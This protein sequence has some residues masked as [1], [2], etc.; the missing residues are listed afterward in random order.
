MSTPHSCGP[1]TPLGLGG[2]FAGAIENKA[3]GSPF[4]VNRL[5]VSMSVYADPALWC[6]SFAVVPGYRVPL[7]MADRRPTGAADRINWWDLTIDAHA[8]PGIAAL[9]EVLRYQADFPNAD[10]GRV[11]SALERVPVPAGEASDFAGALLIRESARW[12]GARPV[13]SRAVLEAVGRRCGERRSTLVAWRTALAGS[14]LVPPYF[15]V[16]VDGVGVLV[17][18]GGH[19]RPAVEFSTSWARTSSRL[20]PHESLE[21]DEDGLGGAFD[22]IAGT[23]TAACWVRRGLSAGNSLWVSATEA[24]AES[25]EAVIAA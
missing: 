22:E 1:D 2:D 21:F 17:G 15:D 8:W 6:P 10:E 23:A 24:I 18:V 5:G 12:A 25:V 4:N 9:Q 13:L 19:D 16:T 20:A 14:R 3:Y 7:L 11:L